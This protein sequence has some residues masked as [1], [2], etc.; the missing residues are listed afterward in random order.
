MLGLRDSPCGLA[1]P[2]GTPNQG[3]G[4][5]GERAWAMVGTAGGSMRLSTGAAKGAS[6]TIPPGV[7]A[8]PT[9]ITTPGKANPASCWPHQCGGSLGARIAARGTFMPRAPQW[10]TRTEDREECECT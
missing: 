9:K 5:L 3:T 10:T 6:I 8:R 1:D 4:V 2:A 7:L